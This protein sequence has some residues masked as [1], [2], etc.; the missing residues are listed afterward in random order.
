MTRF[1]LSGGGMQGSEVYQ[2][3]SHRHQEEE[4]MAKA[5]VLAFL[6]SG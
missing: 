2:D 4:E 6:L 1:K 3:R 5:G